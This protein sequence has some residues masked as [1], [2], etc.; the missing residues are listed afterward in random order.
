MAHERLRIIA[1]LG[2]A[3]A[4]SWLCVS[5]WGSTVETYSPP[6][7]ASTALHSAG[8]DAEP[9]A[10]DQLAPIETAPIRSLDAPQ[11][12]ESSLERFARTPEADDPT[13]ELYA[14]LIEDLRADAAARA[15]TLDKLR[16]PL[17]PEHHQRLLR[18]LAAVHTPDI[19]GVAQQLTRDAAPD[20]RRDGYGLM[21]LSASE[22]ARDTLAHAIAHEADPGALATAIQ[23]FQAQTS[24]PMAVA[25]PMAAR[26]GALTKHPAESVRAAALA[27][28]S[29]LEPQRASE[30]LVEGLADSSSAVV[31]AAL[32]SITSENAHTPELTAELLGLASDTQAPLRL[33]AEAADALLDRT[34]APEDRALI[35]R[36]KSTLEHA[37]P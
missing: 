11:Q 29:G 26:L 34:L 23:S 7:T 31:E 15:R 14:Q 4:G 37:A 13:G 27:T 16:E 20:I 24:V 9:I 12:A 2:L 22:L 32:S 30:T 3:A 19:L 36:F 18:L 35:D 5:A 21:Q 8:R 10:I 6:L 17:P 25:Q 33:R 28:L 1:G